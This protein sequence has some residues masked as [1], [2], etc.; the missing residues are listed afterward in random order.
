Q[1]FGDTV[2]PTLTLRRQPVVVFEE[3]NAGGL[4]IL[5]ATVLLDAGV[6]EV[7]IGSVNDAAGTVVVLVQ[8]ETPI[9]A[10]PLMLGAPAAGLVTPQNSFT[11]FSFDAQAAQMHLIFESGVPDRGPSARLVNLTTGQTS[12]ILGADLVGGTFRIPP[13]AA[14]YQVEISHGGSPGAE[15]FTLCLVSPGVETCT[16]SASPI[17]PTAAPPAE[18]PEVSSDPGA[19]VCTVTPQGPSANIRQSATTGSIIVG[20]LP[21]GAQ[22]AV[23]GISPARDFYNVQYNAV[24]GW[25]ALSVVIG[26]GDCSSVPMI[27]PPPVIAPTQPPLPTPSGPCLITMRGEA[28]VYV[29]PMADPSFLYD[30]V[31]PGYQL[32][33]VGRLADN[34]WWK[35][36]YADAWIQTS[37]FGGAADVS[38]NCA[39]LPIVAP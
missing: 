9:A 15:P 4:A 17:Q 16:A 28:L 5:T 36:S 3:P 24:N 39:N 37:L 6:Y 7:E 18:T 21:Q 34:S 31:Q 1:V 11:L 14:Q 8:G 20:A 26:T 10:T 35:T 32:S 30:E 23:L 25:V 29:T 2:Q 27:S 12:G 13:G 19:A 38:G 22:A 33:P